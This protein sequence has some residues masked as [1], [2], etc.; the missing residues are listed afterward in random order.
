MIDTIGK[1]SRY[2]V[3]ADDKPHI[4][5]GHTVSIKYLLLVYLI[6]FCSRSN[7]ILI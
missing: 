5:Y 2:D 7:A 6:E 1:A 4:T 3:W